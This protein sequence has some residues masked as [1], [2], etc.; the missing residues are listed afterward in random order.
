MTIRKAIALAGLVLALAILNP[1]SALANTEGTHCPLNGS[2]SG[3]VSLNVLTGAFTSDAAGIGS[4][5]GKTTTHIEGTGALTPEGTF[6]ASGTAT[7]VAANGD[8]LTGTFTLTTTG[9]PGTTHT[10]TG[11][12]TITGGTGRFADASGTVTSISQVTSSSFV[13]VTLVST[14]EY[15][16]TG[17][18]SFQED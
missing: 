14:V 3:T 5:T 15:T 11:V 7:I 10:T 16:A 18:I 9:P 13:G 12:A 6:A 4:C 1:A 8:Q 17:Q 2:G